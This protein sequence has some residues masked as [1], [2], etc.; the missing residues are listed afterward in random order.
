MIVK[1]AGSLRLKVLGS[2][3][4]AAEAALDGG[5]GVRCTERPTTFDGRQLSRLVAAMARPRAGAGP[6]PVVGGWMGAW[7]GIGAGYHCAQA[8]MPSL[9]VT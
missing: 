4:A 9:S 5:I 3:L 7:L 2:P 6:S 1:K 8:E